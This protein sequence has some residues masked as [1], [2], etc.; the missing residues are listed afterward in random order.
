MAAYLGGCRIVGAA[1]LGPAT[2]RVRFVTT[3]SDRLYQL[4][5][6]RRLVG[7]TAAADERAI[8]GPLVPSAWP[9]HL[10][11]VA[12]EPADR[13]TDYGP[14]LP[15]RPYN[16][17]RL[18]VAASG[19]PAD[20]KYLEVTGGTEPGGAVDPD[21]LI[22]RVL[23]DT[24]RTYAIDTDPLAGSGQWS[25]AVAGA[26]KLGNAGSALAVAA[27]VVAY[28]PDVAMAADGSRLT[29]SAAGGVLT[30]ECSL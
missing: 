5:A 3:Y 7:A 28:P 15:P 6:G 21:N 26:D 18:R 8:V 27:S 25:F 13:L 4:Y 9:E 19:W 24:D 20:S 1:W 29:V 30:V 11:L 14:T 22:D 12:V 17:V 16:R 2:L 23:Y 10:T